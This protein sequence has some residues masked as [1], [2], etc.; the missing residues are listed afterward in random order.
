MVERLNAAVEA[1]GDDSL[2]IIART[3]SRATHGLDEAIRRAELYRSAGADV[4]FVEAPRSV[5]EMRQIAKALPGAKLVANMVEGGKT[6]YCSAAELQE[7]GFSIALYPVT[8]LFAATQAVET[9][10]SEM[11]SAGRVGATPMTSFSQF[12]AMMELDKFNEMAARLKAEP[13]EP[14]QRN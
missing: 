13:G 7:I 9:A 11:R 4:L 14:P 6:P 2:V 8:M 1:R 5:E 3:D 12:N 10:L